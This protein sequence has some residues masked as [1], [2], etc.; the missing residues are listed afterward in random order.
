M[1]YKSVLNWQV[2]QR[3]CWSPNTPALLAVPHRCAFPCPAAGVS[4]DLLWQHIQNGIGRFC[5]FKQD[6]ISRNQLDHRLID[7]N[8]SS[9]P[10]ASHLLFEGCFIGHTEKRPSEHNAGTQWGT[11]PSSEATGMWGVPGNCTGRGCHGCLACRENNASQSEE[12]P[13]PP[14]QPTHKARSP[15]GKKRHPSDTCPWRPATSAAVQPV[16]L[17]SSVRDT[18]LLRQGPQTRGKRL[19]QTHCYF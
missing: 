19:P 7:I 4:H 15:R 16:S 12:T 8:E 5:D 11:T 18:R 6:D 13:H 1:L 17:T 9:V 10:T 2:S 14:L 3:S